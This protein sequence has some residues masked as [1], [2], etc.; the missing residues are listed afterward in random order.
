M[1]NSINPITPLKP[2]SLQENQKIGIE[3]VS[4]NQDQTFSALLKQ[5]LNKL[6]ETQTEAAQA[7]V[8]LVTGQASDF[9]T[10]VIAMEKAGL[11]LGL[12]VTVR[13]KVLEA[14]HEIMRMQI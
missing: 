3:S 9:H 6:D 1:S 14:Y 5:A 8:D 13:N 2:I 12:A 11:A 4:S 7:T 10:P